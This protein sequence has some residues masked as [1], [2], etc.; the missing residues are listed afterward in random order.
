MDEWIPS[1]ETQMAKTTD[2]NAKIRV[3]FPNASL[4]NNDKRSHLKTG[5]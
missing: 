2:Q 5:K 4:C 3:A 1:E